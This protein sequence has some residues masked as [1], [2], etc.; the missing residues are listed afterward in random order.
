K[1]LL[2]KKHQKVRRQRHD[3]HHTTALALVRQYDTVYFEAIQPANL[4]RRPAPQP[5]GEGGY[6]PN[7]ATR[8]AGL[9]KSIHDARWG[10]F[11]SILTFKA[12]CAG[13]RVEAVSPAYTSQDCSRCRKPIQK[14]LLVRTPVC[15][16]C[17]LV[18]D[19]DE[20]AASNMQWAGRA[21]RGLA[22]LS[23]GM[24]R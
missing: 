22:E 17:G 1:R 24:N 7:G 10:H 2:A 8:K 20:N 12:A 13:T 9:H 4:S 3:F 16:T 11:L 19:R 23:A 21:L 5:D 14:S 18:M 6:L 15:T